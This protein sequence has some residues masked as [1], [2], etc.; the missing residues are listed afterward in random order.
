MILTVQELIVDAMGLI[1]AT[2][3]E[4]TPT[5]SE[6]NLGLRTAN[7][8][9]SRWA[10]MPNM[11]R[12][13]ESLSFTISPGTSDYT[14]G[15]WGANV[16]SCKPV[17]ITDGHIKDSANIIYSLEIVDKSVIEGM[18]DRIV[19]SGRPKML[20]YDPVAT[21]QDPSYGYFYFYYT[22]DQ[23]YT[24]ELDCFFPANTFTS[25]SQT[26][27]FE[28][29]YYEALKYGLAVRL[30]RHYHAANVP[31]PSDIA[32]IAQDTSKTLSTLNSTIPRAACD[33]PSRSSRYNIYTDG[34]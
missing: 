28:P 27:D 22:P 26:V 18:Q 34:G 31:V 16:N 1:G 10:S 19:S 17:K 9:L 6:L 7:I 13:R 32:A 30:F 29:L 2:A 5:D 12:T 14:V 3:I 24:V 23:I 8:M 4:E 33:L 11:M 21:Q 15:E 20:A 25:L